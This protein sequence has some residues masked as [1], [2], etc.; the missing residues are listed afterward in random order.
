LTLRLHLLAGIAALEAEVLRIWRGPK[1][2]LAMA[3]RQGRFCQSRD[4]QERGLLRRAIARID[5]RVPGGANCYRRV[6]METL[7]DSAAARDQ[8]CFGLDRSLDPLS[9]HA[10]LAS[11]RCDRSF[12]AIIKL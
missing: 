12:S 10:W 4:P 5:R 6:L 2:A 3:R 7:L 11:D 9:G 1:V 8:I